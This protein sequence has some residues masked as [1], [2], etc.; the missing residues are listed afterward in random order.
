MVVR[1][2]MLISILAQCA[3]PDYTAIVDV[4]IQKDSSGMKL[5]V[6]GDDFIINGM[7]WDYYPIGTNYTY[8]LWDQPD[9]FIKTALES[10]MPLLKNMGVNTVRL[11]ADVPPDWISYIY[12][13]YGIYTMLNHTFGRYGLTINGNWVANT[14]YANPDAREVLL[15]E[16]KGLAEVYKGTPGLLLYLLGN[17]NNYGL[18]WESAETEDIPVLDSL[19][20]ALA[21]PLYTLFNEA[22]LI[23]KSIDPDRPVAICNGDL[24]FLDII[25]VEC[26]DIDI[27]GTNMYRGESF[28]DISKK[29]NPFQK[30]KDDLNLPILFT[31]LGADAFNVVKK[32]EDQLSQAY[33]VVGNWNEIYGHT[34]GMGN[35][36][37]AIGGFTFQF[38]DGWWKFD[39]SKNL[40][41]HDDHASW[42][43]GGYKHD[44]VQGQDNMNEE[45]FGVCAKGETDQNGHYALFP[46]AA[47]YALK[48][49]HALN[50][51]ADGAT[52]QTV[53]NHFSSIRLTDALDKATRE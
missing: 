49:V 42:S 25:S 51:Y 44:F 52:L 22:A 41:V 34:A 24:Q 6:N 1:T 29:E 46:R 8:S 19:S 12:H 4:A 45:W 14:N 5:V 47:Y 30:V 31:E 38:S 7:N 11:F 37:N 36:G 39:Q 18:F 27:L 15:S 13:Q 26:R 48:E 32:A 21:R 3:A 16:V 53:N 50:P 35:A 2:I 20:E 9:D 10:E 40:D 17:E 23:I 28:Y 43:N 33:Y